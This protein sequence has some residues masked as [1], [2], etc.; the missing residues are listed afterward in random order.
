MAVNKAERDFGYTNLKNSRSAASK[1]AMEHCRRFSDGKAGCEVVLTTTK[2]FA[3]IRH[4]SEFFV[5]EASS[6]DRAALAVASACKKKHGS[7]CR[8]VGEHQ[9]CASG[10]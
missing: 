10:N 7:S 5:E 3:V 8:P 9:H 1:R 2:C 6:K 4:G